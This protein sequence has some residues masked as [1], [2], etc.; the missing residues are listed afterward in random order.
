MHKKTFEMKSYEINFY[1][2]AV[3]YALKNFE[4]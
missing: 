3:T 1:F 2:L 4:F